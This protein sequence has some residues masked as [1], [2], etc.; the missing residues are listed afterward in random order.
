MNANKIFRFLYLPSFRQTSS[1]W[2][3]CGTFQ[4]I[5]RVITVVLSR[6][7]LLLLSI[8]AITTPR[9]NHKNYSNA[10][11]TKKPLSRLFVT[12]NLPQFH[13]HQIITKRSRMPHIPK[14]R[15]TNT[16]HRPLI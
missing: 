5:A 16:I 11:P 12:P 9:H 1:A 7:T 13:L 15:R 14:L 10:H 8:F 3:L 4:N 6:R 2:V